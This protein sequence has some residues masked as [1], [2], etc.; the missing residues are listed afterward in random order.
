MLIQKFERKACICIPCEGGTGHQF[1]EE[2]SLGV[3]ALSTE[4][5]LQSMAL[6]HFHV[7]YRHDQKINPCEYMTLNTISVVIVGK[8]H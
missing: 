3:L 8:G 2:L 5:K 1:P 7:L 6:R 4:L